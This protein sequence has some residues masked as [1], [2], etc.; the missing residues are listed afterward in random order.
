MKAIA[1]AKIQVYAPDSREFQVNVFQNRAT[2]L[3]KQI[4]SKQQHAEYKRR[5]SIYGSDLVNSGKKRLSQA[6]T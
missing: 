2:G 1:T 4:S 3:N 5:K 6:V